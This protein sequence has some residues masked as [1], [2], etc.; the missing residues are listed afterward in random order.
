MPEAMIMHG[1]RGHGRRRPL[2]LLRIGALRAEAPA[3]VCD[4]YQLAWSV[5]VGSGAR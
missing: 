1:T 5:S 4:G 3:A 2:M